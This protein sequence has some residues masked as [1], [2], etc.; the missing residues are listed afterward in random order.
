M[1]CAVA[2]CALTSVAG[3]ATAQTTPAPKAAQKSGGQLNAS[4]QQRGQPPATVQTTPP[5]PI[6]PD[7]RR[8]VPASIF[9]SFDANQKAVAAKVSAYLSSLQTLVGNFVQVGPDGSKTKGDFYIQKPGKVRFEYEPPT[10]IDIIADGSS[11]VV[12]DRKLATQ[13]VYPLSQTPLRYLL[14]D[15][16]DLLK[17]TNV[18]AVTADELYVTITIEEKQALI[19]TSRLML[20]LGAKDG[21]LKQWTVTDP[22]GYDTTIAV[23][24]L[25]TTKKLDPAMF[26]IDFTNYATPPG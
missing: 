26:K 18:I 9:T 14:S 13:D 3:H 25:D 2:A 17:D 22:Q 21:Q 19:G 16:I 10:P 11:L 23:Y 6:I 12:R 4:D 15:R 20:M 24:N 8:N 7:P 1:A 5:N